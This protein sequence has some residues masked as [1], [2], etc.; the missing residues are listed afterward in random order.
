[1]FDLNLKPNALKRKDLDG[2]AP[3]NQEKVKMPLPQDLR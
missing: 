3:T 1:M 2:K